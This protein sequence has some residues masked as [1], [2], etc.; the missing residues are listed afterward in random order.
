M[1]HWKKS[2]S[3]TIVLMANTGD[4]VSKHRPLCWWR[5]YFHFPVNA[6]VNGPSV[7]RREDR[8]THQQ[9]HHP[10]DHSPD[11]QSHQYPTSGTFTDRAK[12]FMT[13]NCTNS[14]NSFF[15]L[16]QSLC[17]PPT[18]NIDVIVC[19][20]CVCVS[21]WAVV[22]SRKLWSL[23]SWLYFNDSLIKQNIIN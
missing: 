12:K 3:T 20:A 15:L 19:C 17:S 22:V 13:F 4:L 21:V 14:G 18:L 5:Q 23:L 9:Q 11:I 2:T 1:I 10:D 7:G 8:R 6:H 16:S